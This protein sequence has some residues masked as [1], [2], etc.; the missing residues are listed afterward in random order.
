VNAETLRERA[1]RMKPDADAVAER[2]PGQANAYRWGWDEGTDA[3][4]TV[5]AADTE[6]IAGVLAEHQPSS[7]TDDAHHPWKC[8]CACGAWFYLLSNHQAAAVTAY[9]TGDPRG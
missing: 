7:H 9:L 4:L 8:R 1:V 6:G 5:V 2:F 3:A